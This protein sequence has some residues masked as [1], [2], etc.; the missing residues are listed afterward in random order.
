MKFNRE[1]NACGCR[2]G[3]LGR[4]GRSSLALLLVLVMIAASFP[5]GGGYFA[6]AEGLLQDISGSDAPAA[7][8]TVSAGDAADASVEEHVCVIRS[9]AG[10]VP[11]EPVEHIVL[12]GAMPLNRI[13][14][15][16]PRKL[17]AVIDCEECS[18]EI[19]ASWKN[20]GTERFELVLDNEKYSYEPQDDPA[21]KDIDESTESPWCDLPF[22]SVTIEGLE[23]EVSSSDVSDSDLPSGSDVASGSDAVSGSDVISG[24]DAVSGSDAASGSDVVT[25]KPAEAPVI[26]DS[27]CQVLPLCTCDTHCYANAEAGLYLVNIRC[28]A[29]SIDPS[30][31]LVMPEF[32]EL[33]LQTVTEDGRSVSVSGQLPEGAVLKAEVVP[34][35]QLG[36]VIGEAGFIV[37]PVVRFA[38]DITILYEGREFQPVDFGGSVRVVI[39]DACADSSEGLAVFHVAEEGIERVCVVED[40]SDAVF[41]ADR[42]SVYVGLTTGISDIYC[43]GSAFYTDSALNNQ[44]AKD[45]VPYST[46]SGILADSTGDITFHVQSAYQVTGAETINPGAG[47]SVSFER[48]SGNTGSIIS[49]AGGGNLTL[50]GAVTVDGKNVAAD[51]PNINVADG[52]ALTMNDGVSV[53]NGESVG[54]WVYEGAFFTMNGGLIAN[55]KAVNGAALHNAGTA[56]MNGGTM[57]G[58]VSVDSGGAVWQQGT[59]TMN[60]GLITGNSCTTMFGGGVFSYLGKTT[61][62]GGTIT[63]NSSSTHPQSSGVSTYAPTAST[64][65]LTGSPRIEDSV[66]VN[67][68]S[69]SNIITV[70]DTFAPLCAVVLEGSGTTQNVVQYSR[71]PNASD[72]A[73]FT[74]RNS[75]RKLKI[76]GNYIQISG[77]GQSFYGSSVGAA[78][79]KTPQTWKL[80]I[81]TAYSVL[82]TTGGTA[83][84]AHGFSV[85]TKATS[86]NPGVT[87][88]GTQYKVQNSVYQTLNS[89]NTLTFRRWER[90]TALNS[91]ANVHPTNSNSSLFIA[92]ESGSLRIQDVTIDGGSQP[93]VMVYNNTTYQ[94][95]GIGSCTDATLLVQG[96]AVL[97]LQGNVVLRN[98]PASPVGGAIRANSGTLNINGTVTFSNNKT[99]TYGKAMYVQNATVNINTPNIINPGNEDFYLA[100]STSKLTINTNLTGVM[101]IT[102]NPNDTA[103]CMPGRIIATYKAGLT[104]DVSK[105]AVQNVECVLVRDGQNIVIGTCEKTFTAHAED[106][107]P[108]AGESNSFTI[109]LA[110]LYGGLGNISGKTVTVTGLQIVSNSG[111]IIIEDYQTVESL[112]R[113]YGR[114]DSNK[115]FGISAGLGDN[116][117]QDIQSVSAAVGSTADSAK[118]VFTVHSG[119]AITV[120][121]QLAVLSFELNV[122][123]SVRYINVTLNAHS[124]CNISAS[125]PIKIVGVVDARGEFTL[126]DGSEYYIANKGTVPL[127]LTDVEWTWM[128]D[129]AYDADEMFSRH[130]NISLAVRLGGSGAHEFDSTL[131]YQWS[132]ISMPISARVGDEPG[133]LSLDWTMKMGSGNILKSTQSATVANITYTIAVKE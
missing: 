46:V 45:G 11:G 87:V 69:A 1:K 57:S 68:G 13:K 7:D 25:D 6:G 30:G 123:G 112:R 86:T 122:G 126:P 81:N 22:V 75:G 47:R 52:G 54:V 14:D 80:L 91:T 84:M 4:L 118:M 15:M 23:A 82:R 131:G 115:Y 108:D 26:S 31:C 124:G 50:S 106:V 28:P 17:Q 97:D 119:N 110:A 101:P 41:S 128:V 94:M 113:E 88:S 99:S 51:N 78:D 29:C 103:S 71:T 83:F 24:S 129:G 125:V 63:G 40:G 109:D 61:I 62:A 120:D 35:D 38:Y 74:V 117:P 72:L 127:V 9:F 8:V 56:V 114:A 43:S 92:T 85:N 102:I 93:G 133:K 60:G 116:D 53:V 107:T 59:F 49:V 96:S 44:L 130:E 10:Y 121:G 73:C 79:A 37:T 3:R 105:F 132:G 55:N 100:N 2:S 33:T 98:A 16:L 58:N 65:V 66:Y 77:A 32:A 70:T 64:L 12:P 48:V 19:E 21:T 18:S 111:N 34:E 67:A 39:S 42:F 27:D 104:P 90:P 36:A 20:I 5:V 76:N 89:G 95:N